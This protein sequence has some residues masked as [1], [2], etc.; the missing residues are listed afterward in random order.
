LL[1]RVEREKVREMSVESG[2]EQRRGETKREVS[3]DR[4]PAKEGEKERSTL[5]WQSRVRRRSGRR[6]LR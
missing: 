1:L 2:G 6:D 3:V 5:V 4:Q